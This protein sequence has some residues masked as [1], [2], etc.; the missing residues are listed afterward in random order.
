MSSLDFA[1]A[2]FSKYH[3]AATSCS[4]LLFADHLTSPVPTSP[5]ATAA[6]SSCALVSSGYHLH[7][8]G[9]RGRPLPPSSISS[10][11]SSSF[12]PS[13]SSSSLCWS[14]N[15]SGGSARPSAQPSEP[16]EVCAA[17]PQ[18]SSPQGCATERFPGRSQLCTLAGLFEPPCRRQSCPEQ[19][20]WQLNEE[21]PRIYPWMRSSGVDRRRGRQTYTRH[22]TL[23]LEKE[24]HYSRYLTR[25]RR[26]EVAH[27]LLLTERQIK[28]WFQNR[29]MKWKKE[30]QATKGGSPT[31]ALP[32]T[33]EEEGAEEEVEEEEE[34][35]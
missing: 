31:A 33:G 21:E 22:Q 25:R 28:I 15:R 10:S 19:Q 24:F 17:G 4:T 18:S 14:L 13:C 29:R 23:E 3:R 16:V 5:T 35:E 30:N 8:A 27:A 32:T 11:S 7:A 26:V 6:S 2:L 12:I 34:E 9:G 1:N 20:Q